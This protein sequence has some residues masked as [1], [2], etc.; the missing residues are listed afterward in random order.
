MVFHYRMRYVNNG[1]IDQG[2]QAMKLKVPFVD[3]PKSAKD[4]VQCRIPQVEILKSFN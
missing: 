2:F 3:I 1:Q 4:D